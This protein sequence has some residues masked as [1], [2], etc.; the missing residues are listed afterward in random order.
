MSRFLTFLS[1]YTRQISGLHIQCRVI[2]L[3]KMGRST[4]RQLHKSLDYTK[5]AIRWR[6]VF[7]LSLRTWFCCFLGVDLPKAQPGNPRKM[8]PI[9]LTVIAY[10]ELLLICQTHSCSVVKI[11]CS[12]P[13]KLTAAYHQRFLRLRNLWS[14]AR[15]VSQTCPHWDPL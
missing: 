4:S 2:W 13:P 6:K 1:L 8:S 5:Q 15:Y 10:L 9:T 3:N 14:M 12:L 11:D 7:E